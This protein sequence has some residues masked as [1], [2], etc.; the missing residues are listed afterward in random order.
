MTD[1][2]DLTVGELVEYCRTQARLLAG[3]L[4][5]LGNDIEDLLDEVETETET[6]Q[7]RLDQQQ[8]HTD[9]TETPPSPGGVTDEIDIGEIESKQAEVE[10]KYALM[11]SFESLATGYTELASD[12]E[13]TEDDS[14]AAL[15]AVI[16][17]ETEHDAAEYFEAQNTIA[18]IVTEQ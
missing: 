18:E 14:Y 13:E 6:A 3:Q 9:G 17:F 12:L 10:T 5:E 8:Q 7:E 1:D 4:E 15:E 11:R 2:V 16:Q